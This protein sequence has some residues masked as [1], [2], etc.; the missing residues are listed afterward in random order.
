MEVLKKRSKVRQFFLRLLAQVFQMESFNDVSNTLLL[1]L[2]VCLC[3]HIGL[4]GNNEQY[5]S[6]KHLSY[7]NNLIKGLPD[8]KKP[9][10]Q[11]NSDDEN[12]DSDDEMEG[13]QQPENLFSN[14]DQRFEGWHR[15]TKSLF[16]TAE[17][18]TSTTRNKSVMNLNPFFIKEATKNQGSDVLLTSLDKNYVSDF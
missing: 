10:A 1:L 17:K 14:A 4:D 5:Q 18:I 6:E 7:I 12:D 16:E 2:V 11:E 8:I 15:W 9:V 13:L 3:E